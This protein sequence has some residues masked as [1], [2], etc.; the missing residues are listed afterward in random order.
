MLILKRRYEFWFCLL[1][2]HKL[3]AVAIPATHLLTTK[4][5][6]Y[7]NNAAD[8]KAIVAVADKKIQDCVDA[9]QADSPT[10]AL[11]IIVGGQHE[12]WHDF[13]AGLA[14]APAEFARPTGAAATRNEDT[15]LL[16][17]TSGTTGY[18]K[19][20]RHDVLPPGSP[21]RH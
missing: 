20:V 21:D 15:L 11:K 1:A 14:Q 18:P 8:I 13:N 4:D 6:V 5:I 9:A 16:Y 17:F 7:R 12:G 19:M 10:L 3:G 2:L